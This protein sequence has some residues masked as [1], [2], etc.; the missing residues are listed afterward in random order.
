VEGIIWRAKFEP[1]T[2]KAGEAVKV[3]AVEGL[4]LVVEKAAADKT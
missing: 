4:M 2:A 3:K 1:G